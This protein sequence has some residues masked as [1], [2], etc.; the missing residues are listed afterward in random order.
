MLNEIVKNLI[1]IHTKNF[2]SY[3]FNASPEKQIV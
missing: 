1:S 3:S 2:N